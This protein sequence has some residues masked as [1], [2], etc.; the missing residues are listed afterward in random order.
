MLKKNSKKVK[1]G[2]SFVVID[3]GIKYIDEAIDN[4]AV[5]IIS[6]QKYKNIDTLIVN[7]PLNYYNNYIYN[8]YYNKIKDIKL[9]GIFIK[10]KTNAI[11]E[12]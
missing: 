9:I 8:I 5:R 2:D 6:T 3:D 12:L 4:G 1:P 11:I 7:D 10:F